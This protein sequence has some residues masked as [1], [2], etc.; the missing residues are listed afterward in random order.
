M[1]FST[2]QCPRGAMKHYRKI[3]ITALLF[4][5]LTAGCAQSETGRTLSLDEAAS[6]SGE[7]AGG[8]VRTAQ[9]ETVFVYVC[10]KVRSP[11]V[12]ELPS[13]ARVCDAIEA[14][15]G[16][17]KSADP[18]SVNQAEAL[19]DGTRIYIPSKKET[20][21]TSGAA[22]DAR[23]EGT[24]SAGG[25]QLSPGMVNLN[26]ASKDELMTL[27]GI[28]ESKAQSILDYRQENG[29]FSRTEDIMNISGIKEGVFNKIK[30]S[31]TV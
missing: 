8:E 11:G 10:G 26:T 25:A 15:G 19:K 9:T 7:T 6:A 13:A 23:P 18:E 20:S 17:L 24:V 28:G 3:L 29:S 5:C 1:T 21:G 16:V 14:A 22:S 2:D 4:A 27:P 30:D 31:I 12:Y